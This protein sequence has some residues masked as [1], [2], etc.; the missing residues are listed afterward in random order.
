M[1]LA[2]ELLFE[3]IRLQKYPN[4]PSRLRSLWLV[5]DLTELRYWNERL[6]RGQQGVSLQFVQVI[7][8]GKIT[9]CDASILVG[10][11]ERVS[12]SLLKADRYWSGSMAE[13]G[14]EP[15]VLFE[16]TATVSRILDPSELTSA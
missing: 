4:K 15:E 10:D 16:G 5:S 12:E 8:T 1:L 2:R 13:T 14:A 11:S 7:A 6:A 9:R 3:N